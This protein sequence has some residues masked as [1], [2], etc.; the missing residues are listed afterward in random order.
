MMI[1]NDLANVTHHLGSQS[2]TQ[3]MISLTAFMHRSFRMQ[4]EQLDIYSTPT[5]LEVA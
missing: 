1:G 5:L 4:Q 2:E 3:I